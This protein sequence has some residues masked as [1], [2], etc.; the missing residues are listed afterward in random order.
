MQAITF[1]K[2][3]RFLDTLTQELTWFSSILLFCW[4]ILFPSNC[5]LAIGRNDY[6]WTGLFISALC[7][8]G[9]FVSANIIIRKKYQEIHKFKFSNF[10]T[11][12]ANYRHNKKYYDLPYYKRCFRNGNLADLPLCCFQASLQMSSCDMST[13]DQKINFKSL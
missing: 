12:Q 3:K 11:Y 2:K 6:D 10:E 4:T 8:K 5:H 7:L 13:D 1:A 9:D